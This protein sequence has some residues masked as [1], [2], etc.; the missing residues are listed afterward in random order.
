MTSGCRNQLTTRFQLVK[1]RLTTLFRFHS[2]NHDLTIV[3]R[4]LPTPETPD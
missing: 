1:F 4:P 2:E 3:K